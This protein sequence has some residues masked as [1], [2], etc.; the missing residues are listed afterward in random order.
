MSKQGSKQVKAYLEG[1]TREAQLAF[2]NGVAGGGAHDRE[3]PRVV[4][5]MIRDLAGQYIE[6]TNDDTQATDWNKAWADVRH[7]F[8]SAWSSSR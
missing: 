5:A 6:V 3:Q 7:K 8:T 4:T 1:T 2:A